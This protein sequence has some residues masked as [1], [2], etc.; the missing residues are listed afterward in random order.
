VARVLDLTGGTYYLTLSS[1]SRRLI[2]DDP[3]DVRCIEERIARAVLRNAVS[4]HAYCWLRRELHLAVEL[5]NGSIGSFVRTLAAGVARE[6]NR[7]M[8]SV[9]SLFSPGYGA[10][11]IHTESL[12]LPL[13]RYLHLLPTYLNLVRDPSDYPWSSH[14]AYL[15]TAKRAPWLTPA[16]ALSLLSD[17]STEAIRRYAAYS[18]PPLSLAECAG[19]LRRSVRTTIGPP[20]WIHAI[21]HKKNSRQRVPP[22]EQFLSESAT[23]LGYSLAALQSNSRSRVLSGA[24]ALLAKAAIEQGFASL[25]EVARAF[26]RSPC[27][28]YLAIEAY[29]N[30]IDK[31]Q[32]LQN[33]EISIDAA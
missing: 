1:C 20:E 2:I 6:K 17:E 15:S 14:N 19:F 5:T 30:R 8:N 23:R 13:V 29:N 24:R 16:K 25:S 22:I 18:E 9:G 32:K 31:A 33:S 21:C 11:L 12:L 26:N 7:R 28:I 27:T 4:V 10:I 3:Q